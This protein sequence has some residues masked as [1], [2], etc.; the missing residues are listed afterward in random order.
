MSQSI[1]GL[2]G[3]Q[4]LQFRR[5]FVELA[6]VLELGRFVI[7]LFTGGHARSTPSEVLGDRDVSCSA[8][9]KCLL[10]TSVVPVARAPWRRF[11]IV[12]ANDSPACEFTKLRP[13]SKPGRG[14]KLCRQLRACSP[15]IANRTLAALHAA[16]LQELVHGSPSGTKSGEAAAYFSAY[17]TRRE[18]SRQALRQTRQDGSTAYPQLKRPHR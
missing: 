10:A 3:Q 17:E 5:R 2:L 13:Q 15:R 18:V 4:L 9:P 8:T 16:H 11:G 1:V 12:E 7:N 6:R 14:G